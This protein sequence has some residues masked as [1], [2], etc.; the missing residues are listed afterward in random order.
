MASSD[1]GGQLD[2]Q[3]GDR[4]DG[5]DHTCGLGD[6]CLAVEEIDREQV[7]EPERAEG[8]GQGGLD[9]GHEAVDGAG[10]AR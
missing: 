10:P 1:G 5:L 4:R 3:A 6:P 7:G 2:R 8:G 9:P